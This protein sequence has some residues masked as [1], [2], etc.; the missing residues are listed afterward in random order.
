M[1]NNACLV[2]KV[3]KDEMVLLE[4]KVIGSIRKI[5]KDTDQNINYLKEKELVDIRQ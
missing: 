2:H 4:P 1:L 3:P 5:K